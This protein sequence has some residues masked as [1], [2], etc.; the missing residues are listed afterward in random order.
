MQ[1]THTEAIVIWLL[2]ASPFVLGSL[3]GRP[4]RKAKR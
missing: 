2:L 1:I 3:F 4:S